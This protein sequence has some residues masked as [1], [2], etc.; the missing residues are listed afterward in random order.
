V[1]YRGGLGGSHPP[2]PKFRSFDKVE[3]DCKLSGKYLV[4][5]F[6]HPNSFKNCWI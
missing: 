4:F 1:A 2:P 5:L 6:R 3:L